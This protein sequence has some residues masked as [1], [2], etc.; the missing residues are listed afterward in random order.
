MSNMTA[1]QL[2]E[3]NWK[4]MSEADHQLAVMAWAEAA[5]HNMPLLDLLYHIPN[6]SGLP[7]RIAGRVGAMF[8]RMGLKSGMPDLHLPVSRVVRLD[9][10]Q[11]RLHSIYVEMK[12][13][14]GSI[15]RAQKA[16]ALKLQRQ[17]N[18]VV[19]AYNHEQAE[20]VLTDYLNDALEIPVT[21][22]LEEA[23]TI[24]TASDTAAHERG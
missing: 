20:Q 2:K 11:V 12:K 1:Q 8:K 5:M 23:R 10:V 15:S 4:K 19:F 6:Q 9:G 18:A 22:G 13:P 24:C 14:G 17:G 7:S 3:L 21:E 16:R